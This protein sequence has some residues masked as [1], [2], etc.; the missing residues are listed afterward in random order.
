MQNQPGQPTESLYFEHSLKNALFFSGKKLGHIPDGLG[1]C[2]SSR[3][4]RKEW[5]CAFISTSES[6]ECA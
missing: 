3:Q 5:K 6:A 2:K 4:L 1:L